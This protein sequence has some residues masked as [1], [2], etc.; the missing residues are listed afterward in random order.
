MSVCNKDCYTK[1]RG[2][3][4]SPDN[5]C[6]IMFHDENNNLHSN[7]FTRNFKA[8]SDKILKDYEQSK[9]KK[10]KRCL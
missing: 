4:I 6:Y 3:V 1:G 7:N 2:C 10:A 8:A 9:T 5:R